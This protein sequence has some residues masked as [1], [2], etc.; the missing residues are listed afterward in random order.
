MSEKDHFADV[1]ARLHAGD[2]QA[3]LEV[4]QR[5]AGR[6]IGL[7]RSHL[8]SGLQAKVDAEDVLQ[9]AW[10]SFFLRQTDG[11]FTLAGWDDLWALLVV[12]TLRKCNRKVE[13][14]SA[15]RRDVLREV[16][17]LSEE[18][19]RSWSELAGGPAPSDGLLLAEVVEGV[20]RTL[21]GEHE[22]QILL[23]SLQGYS[24]E[25][26]GQQVRRTERTV[27]RVLAR[28]RDQLIRMRDAG[29]E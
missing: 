25:E 4:F 18:D 22:R 5:F 8:V 2:Q 21:L 19:E 15:A 14:F 16:R 28:I 10:K 13:H 29:A 12:I 23:L 7:A 9:S 26:V 27:R 20:M 3:A 1:M 6:L 11:Q 17:T 24:T